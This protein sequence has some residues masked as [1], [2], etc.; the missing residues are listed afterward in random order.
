VLAPPSGMYGGGNVPASVR[1]QIGGSVQAF[2]V[3]SQVPLQHSMS[4]AHAWPVAPQWLKVCTPAMHTPV[5]DGRV[6]ST[7][8][9]LSA[10]GSWH[11]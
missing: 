11:L 4:F 10:F 1:L 9:A 6:R 8:V 2:F 3:G 5:V 7:I